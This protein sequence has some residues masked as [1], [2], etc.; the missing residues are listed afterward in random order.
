MSSYMNTLCKKAF[1]VLSVID[2]VP[3]SINKI[4]NKSG[5]TYC[6]TY[7]TVLIFKEH[8]LIDRV[9]Y[10]GVFLTQKGLQIKNFINQIY[11]LSNISYKR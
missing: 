9:R 6:I 11:T 4:S 8:N 3:T 5:V 10:K 1:L 2:N 7:K